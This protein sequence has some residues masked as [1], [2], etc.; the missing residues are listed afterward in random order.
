M[1]LDSTNEGRQSI[2]DWSYTEN[3][4][5]EKIIEQLDGMQLDQARMLLWEVEQRI[6]QKA[7]V[8]L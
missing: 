1:M 2:K 4:A 5:I 8:R 7:Y 6:S 3:I